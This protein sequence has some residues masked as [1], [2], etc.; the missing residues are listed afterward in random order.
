[1]RPKVKTPA[2]HTDNFAELVCSNSL[3]SEFLTT[4]RGVLIQEMKLFDS[5]IIN[6]ALKSKVPAGQALAVDRDKFAEIISEVISVNPYIEV[7]REEFINIPADVLEANSEYNK[8]K[9]LVIASGPLTSPNLSEEI[10]KLTQGKDFLN[11]FDA[12]S[13]ILT[14]ESINMD[15]A[16]KA[17]RYGKGETDDYINCPFYS[18]DEYYRFQ[19]ALLSAKRAELQDFEKENMRYFEGCMPVEAIAERGKDTLRFGPLKP[20]G[21]TDPRRPNEK[22]YAVVQLRQDNVLGSLYNIVGFQTNLKWGEQ[23]RVFSMIPA[24]ENLDIVRYGVMH[25]NI[26][27]NSPTLLSE[28]LSLKTHPNIYF[29]G[30]ITGVEGYTESA[31]T[32][33]VVARSIVSRILSRIKLNTAI[34]LENDNGAKNEIAPLS[35]LTMLGAL[36]NYVT[37]ADPKRFQPINSNWGLINPN[38][39]E[40]EKKLRKDKRLKNEFLAERALALI[41]EDA[42]TKTAAM[43]DA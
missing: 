40:L 29:A 37:S 18:A 21:L 20:V 27:L 32:G 15:I 19:E 2:H 4:A 41:R 34:D 3:G 35:R 33:I 38:P 1:M 5:L 13:P 14:A 8:N 24:L 28:N 22:P 39:D 12:A 25:Q 7:I 42:F 10:Q 17:S 36:V 16:F 23:K 30:Q 26:F 11:F 43:I 6:S 9:F 31:G